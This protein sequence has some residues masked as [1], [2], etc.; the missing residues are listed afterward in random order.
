MADLLRGVSPERKEK[1]L[2]RAEELIRE[3]RMRRGRFAPPD[4]IQ[5]AAD[6]FELRPANW[7]LASMLA[8]GAATIIALIATALRAA[9]S[10]V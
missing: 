8:M 10:K 2:A 3:E 7:V 4:E 9:G 1:I 6:P 5:N